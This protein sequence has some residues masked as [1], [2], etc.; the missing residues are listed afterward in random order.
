MRGRIREVC[1]GAADVWPLSVLRRLRQHQEAQQ[2]VHGSPRLKRGPLL[3]FLSKC[4]LVAMRVYVCP[5]WGEVQREGRRV[6]LRPSVGR[7]ELQA[8]QLDGD[9]AVLARKT[10]IPST[11][12]GPYGGHIHAKEQEGEVTMC[13]CVCICVSV[14]DL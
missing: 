12:W 5:L 8:G 6:L 11:L 14:F 7:D 10:L 2:E 3:L 13:V 4:P 1:A 9:S